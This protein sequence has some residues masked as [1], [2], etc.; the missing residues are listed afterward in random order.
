VRDERRQARVST[1]A[2]LMRSG[3]WTATVQ[4]QLREHWKATGNCDSTAEFG[5]CV[6][7]ARAAVQCEIAEDET[8]TGWL[9]NTVREHE[10]EL[11]SAMYRHL[12]RAALYRAK[13]DE[14]LAANELKR[15]VK[16]EFIAT[17]HE[18]LAARCHRDLQG[19]H[20]LLLGHHSEGTELARIPPAEVLKM[21]AAQYG[22]KDGQ[23][24]GTESCGAGSK[25]AL[26]PSG[27]E[28]QRATAATAEPEQARTEKG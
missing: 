26:G 19:Y 13:A 1:I 28:A 3:R 17:R 24:D 4:R 2:R 16:F 22:P 18:E 12:E 20:G 9:L 10:Q 5:R 15:L 27:D 23:P 14:L 25:Q 21:L 7:A 6:I 8:T 11:A